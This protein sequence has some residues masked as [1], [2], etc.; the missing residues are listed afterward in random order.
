[1]E[2]KNKIP[3]LFKEILERPTRKDSPSEK[4]IGQA[5]ER[6]IIYDKINRKTKKELGK[7]IPNPFEVKRLGDK[8]FACYKSELKLR[9]LA[10]QQEA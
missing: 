6:D 3:E 4:I 2:K 9:K 10:E 8:F 7:I 1:M 5:F